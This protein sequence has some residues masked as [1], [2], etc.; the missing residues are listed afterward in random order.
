VLGAILTVAATQ[1]TPWLG[2][3]LLA[4]YAL[5]MAAPL[6]VLALLWKRFDLAGRRFL[7]GRT[8]A[9]GPLRVHTT[10]AVSGL[11]FVG[12]GVLFLRYD[13]TAGLA[14]ALG[15]PDLTDLETSAQEWVARTT[16]GVPLWVLPALVALGAGLMAWRRAR[17][18]DG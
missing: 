14:P 18:P 3:L 15:V 4:V 11:L 17:Q 6:L 13:G 9:W 7:R 8:L 1:S 10:S 5:G 12:I 16:A 2:G